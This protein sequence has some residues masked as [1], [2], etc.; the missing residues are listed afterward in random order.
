M[1]AEEE[2]EKYRGQNT[3]QGYNYSYVRHI[4]VPQHPPQVR[5]GNVRTQIAKEKTNKI[6]DTVNNKVVKQQTVSIDQPQNN[7][8]QV[9][10]TNLCD[11]LKRRRQVAEA[12]GDQRLLRLLEVEWK[13]MAC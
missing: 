9:H 12:K 13:Y 6:N 4:P 11:I 1:M 7:I 10:R 8:A 3:G 5:F 2:V